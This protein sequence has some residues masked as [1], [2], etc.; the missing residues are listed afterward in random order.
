MR[1]ARE[2]DLPSATKFLCPFEM[3][4]SKWYLSSQMQPSQLFDSIQPFLWALWF[5]FSSSSA[6]EGTCTKRVF[7][8]E[9][10]PSW[11]LEIRGS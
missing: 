7:G 1:G 2:R 3:T 10:E 11:K 4:M 8:S 6:Q 9:E 5:P